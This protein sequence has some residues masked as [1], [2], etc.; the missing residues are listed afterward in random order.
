MLIQIIGLLLGAAANLLTIAL[1]AR[2]YAQW[3]RA[4]FR[5]PLGRFLLAVTDWAVLPL[6]RVIPG[7]FGVD[8]ASVCAAWL[9]QIVYFGVMTALIGQG[10]ALGVILIAGIAVLSMSVYLLMGVVIVTAVLSWIN[11]HSPF[12]PVFDALSRPLLAPVRRV[13]PLL[14]G[15]DLSPLV[16]L[17]L[18]QVVLIVLDNLRPLTLLLP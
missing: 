6:R 9:T 13:L 2:A 8:L 1:L 10:I 15:I 18:L 7:L 5:N 17:L 16:V 14:G 3:V 11:P 4:P 12:T